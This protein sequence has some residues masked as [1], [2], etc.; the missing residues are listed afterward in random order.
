MPRISFSFSGWITDARVVE[1]YSPEGEMIEVANKTAEEVCDMLDHQGYTLSL[2]DAI[3]DCRKSEIE[4][5][6]YEES[7]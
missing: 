6:D 7:L 2:E 1:L 3:S 5:F 4:I